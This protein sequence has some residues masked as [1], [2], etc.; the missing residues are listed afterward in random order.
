MSKKNACFFCQKPESNDSFFIKSENGNI[1]DQCVEEL[2]T[3]I[4]NAKGETAP[5][6]KNN[7]ISKDSIKEADLEVPSPKEIKKFL[8]Q[9]IIGQENSKITL[10][11]AVY[12]HYKRVNNLSKIKDGDIEIEKSNILMIGETGTGKTMLAKTIAKKLHVPFYIADATALTQA[13]YVG[14]DVEGM[15]TGLLQASDYDL[16]KAEK[17]IVFIDEIDKIARKGDNPSITR[18]VSGEG[19]QQSL[20]KILEGAI[21]NV[22][23]EGGRKH[24]NQEFIKV[25]TQNILFIGGGAFGGIDRIIQNRYSLSS[26]GFTNSLNRTQKNLE[27]NVYD[28]AIAD[29]LKKFGLIPEILGRFPVICGLEP[30]TTEHLKNILTEPKNAIIKQYK[31]LFEWDGVDLVFE[32]K[33]IDKIVEITFSRKLGARGLRGVCEKI[34]SK[35]MFTL[36]ELKGKKVTIKSKDIESL[37]TN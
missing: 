34:L 21:I 4:Q 10:A 30:L 11:I 33:A 8:D 12:H 29:D 25:N 31:K 27:E 37:V 1:C 26:M 28:L 5:K 20:L 9:Y 19:V 2:H 17:G 32:E 35:Y 15:L 6:Q 18:D 24:P 7:P 16:S 14:E 23:P 13:G 3:L 22:P 36:P